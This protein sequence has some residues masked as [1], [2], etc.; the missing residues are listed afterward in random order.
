[1]EPHWLTEEEMNEFND[2]DE[3]SGAEASCPVHKYY[4]KWFWWDEVWAH[5]YGPFDTREEA[6]KSCGDYAATL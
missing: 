6:S 3:E 5:A 2:C 4:G 1:M